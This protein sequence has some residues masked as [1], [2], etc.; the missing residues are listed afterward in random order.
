LEGIVDRLRD[1]DGYMRAPWRSCRLAARIE[2]DLKCLT[3]ARLNVPA[4]SPAFGL[5]PGTYSTIATGGRR[6]SDDGH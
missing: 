6:C 4:L 3:A 5:V 2:F 1:G